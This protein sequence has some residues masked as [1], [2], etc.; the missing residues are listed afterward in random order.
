MGPQTIQHLYSST[1]NS[2]VEIISC[3]KVL[4]PFCSVTRGIGLQK[5]QA[6]YG[7]VWH[8]H[9]GKVLGVAEGSDFTSVHLICRYCI[10]EAQLLLQ[11][12][13]PNHD[14]SSKRNLT[15]FFT[16]SGFSFFLVW[17]WTSFYPSDPTKLSS[18]HCQSEIW[19]RSHL[20][21]TAWSTVKDSVALW[22]F[23]MTRGLYNVEKAFCPNSLRQWDTAETES[24]PIQC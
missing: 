4:Y 21:H 7:K 12:T 6:N 1:Y 24:Y 13:F 9:A 17:L 3:I 15:N 11:K 18:P 19:S 14:A 22:F 20:F 10:W 23:L 5:V 2:V 16:H 8:G